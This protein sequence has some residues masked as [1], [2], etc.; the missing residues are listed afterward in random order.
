M[1]N[2]AL[3]QVSAS[4]AC[5]SV[6]RHVSA[7]LLHGLHCSQM[8]N[9]IASLLSLGLC[10]CTDHLDCPMATGCSWHGHC[11]EPIDTTLDLD[12]GDVKE[13]SEALI[14]LA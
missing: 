1:S 9:S 6:I 14:G 11:W 2:M 13:L 5:F 8:S 10:E 4:Q 7:Y 3:L 12:L